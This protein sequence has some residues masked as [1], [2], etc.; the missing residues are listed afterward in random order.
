[1]LVVVVCEVLAVVVVEL[2]VED[3]VDVEFVSVVV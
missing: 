3:V 1:M 2:L